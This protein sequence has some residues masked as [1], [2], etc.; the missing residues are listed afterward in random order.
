[1]KDEVFYMSRCAV[2]FL[3]VCSLLQFLIICSLMSVKL[4]IFFFFF[5]VEH[6]PKEPKV[7]TSD[8]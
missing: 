4:L 1:M 5:L 8:L 7:I 6:E 3:V 2:I